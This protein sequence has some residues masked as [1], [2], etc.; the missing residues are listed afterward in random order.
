MLMANGIQ[1]ISLKV[2]PLM[3]GRRMM[4]LNVVGKIFVGIIKLLSFRLIMTMFCFCF[5]QFIFS[6][7]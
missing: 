6:E 7:K 4:F 1:E 3:T 2:N 5:W